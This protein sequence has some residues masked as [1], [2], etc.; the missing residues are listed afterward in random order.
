[1]LRNVIFH[2][3]ENS[4]I[5]QENQRLRQENRDLKKKLKEY[6]EVIQS[7]KEENLVLKWTRK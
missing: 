7:L 4:K 5:S 6:D 3:I 2:T 1:M